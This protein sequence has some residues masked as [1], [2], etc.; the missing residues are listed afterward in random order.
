M[1]FTLEKRDIAAST[2]G[3]V[4]IGIISLIAENPLEIRSGNIALSVI[5]A[6]VYLCALIFGYRAGAIAP[7]GTVIAIGNKG[8]TSEGIQTVLL[9]IIFGVLIGLFSEFTHIMDEGKYVRYMINCYV[10]EFT[11]LLSLF[12]LTRPLTVFII[13][14]M[15]IFQSVEEGMS[16]TLFAML[17][18][19]VGGL[20]V[21]YLIYLFG[22]WKAQDR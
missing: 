21:L 7:L 4:I 12:V 18:S 3:M 16:F 6:V 20:I 15:E 22:K 19:V 10:I 17:F 11:V 9:V 8:I 13:N 2:I 1:K 14:K 5:A